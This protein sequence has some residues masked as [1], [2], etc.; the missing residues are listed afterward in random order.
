MNWTGGRLSRHSGTSNPVKDRQ[1]QHFAKVYQA[2]RSGPKKHSPIKWSFF[3]HLAEDRERGQRESSAAPHRPSQTNSLGENLS[4]RQH[5]GQHLSDKILAPHN[6]RHSSGQREP[7]RSREHLVPIQ[8]PSRVPDNDLY[9]ATPPPPQKVKRKR[10]V[11][12]SKSEMENLA[13]QEMEEE[14][15][16]EKRRKILRKGDWVGVSIQRPLQIAF[17]SPRKE[18]N[19]GR[20]RKLT[21]GHRARYGS[22]QMHVTSPFPTKSRLLVNQGC[23]QEGP[24]Q[25]EPARADV[26]ISIGSRVVPPGVSSSSTP[27]RMGSHPTIAR[28]RSKTASSDV[29]LLDAEAS[30]TQESPRMATSNLAASLYSISAVQVLS[31]SPNVRPINTPLV[32]EVKQG[33]HTSYEAEDAINGWAEKFSETVSKPH[34]NVKEPVSYREFFEAFPGNNNSRVS[35]ANDYSNN[36]QPGRLVFSSSS[37]SIHHPAPRSS[38]V[39]VLLRSASSD[40]AESTLAQVGKVRPVVPS[41][42]I[43]DNE[44]W[45]TWIAPEQN[46]EDSF[47]NA[48]FNE[49]ENGQRVFVS[50]GISTAPAIWHT[51]TIRSKSGER[52]SSELQSLDPEEMATSSNG[53]NVLASGSSEIATR[54]SEV[55]QQDTELLAQGMDEVGHVIAQADPELTKATVL[56]AMP[57]KETIEEDQNESWTK[58]LFG[59]ISDEVDVPSLIPKRDVVA[60]RRGEFFGT[61]ILV[62]ASGD[63]SV[64]SDLNA[65]LQD[66][67]TPAAPSTISR[68]A[69]RITEASSCPS[70][71]R[72]REPNIEMASTVASPPWRRGISV[73]AERGSFLASSSESVSA[74]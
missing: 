18:E 15:L 19:I 4:I 64:L 8:Q 10:E 25:R 40:L 59:G 39:S 7:S 68:G 24:Y 12:V 38:R 46:H 62:Q 34:D 2:L 48:Y 16:S 73:Q 42:Q 47:D 56:T 21:D 41:S 3:D 27:R 14:S 58:F 13:D 29:M 45:K 37:I 36:I 28:R 1:K 32:D 51:E 33:D 35:P 54:S 70:G 6:T 17:V 55:E 53:S 50:P 65:A 63:E 11:S 26:R 31:Q 67:N 5:H 74:L 30:I 22:K 23:S 72:Y 71:S 43:L 9:N 66:T 20:R 52:R 61:S 60:S 44:I 57:D 69:S 49:D